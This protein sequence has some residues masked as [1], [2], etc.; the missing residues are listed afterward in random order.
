MADVV[1]FGDDVVEAE[2]EAA[3]VAGERGM[4]YIS[5]YNDLEVWIRFP[6]FS[7]N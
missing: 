5:P 4:T 1:L 3:R 2:L 7:S 6:E